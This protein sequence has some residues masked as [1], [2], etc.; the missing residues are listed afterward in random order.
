MGG[1][2]GAYAARVVLA[3]FVSLSVSL[4]AWCVAGG[5]GAGAGRDGGAA[6]VEGFGMCDAAVAPCAAVPLSE[7]HF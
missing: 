7:K 6:R 4:A 2:G 5:A 3:P 1:G